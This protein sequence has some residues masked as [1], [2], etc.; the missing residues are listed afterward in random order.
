MSLRYLS[1]AA[2]GLSG[3]AV[4]RDQRSVNVMSAFVITTVVTQV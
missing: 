3:P 1:W 2:K 4:E